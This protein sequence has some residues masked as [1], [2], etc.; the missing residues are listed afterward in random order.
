MIER[1]FRKVAEANKKAREEVEKERLAQLKDEE[2][3]NRIRLLNERI[4]RLDRFP[5]TLAD[6]NI[7]KGKTYEILDSGSSN[8][9]VFIDEPNSHPWI[10]REKEDTESLAKLLEQGCVGFVYYQKRQAWKNV[11][12]SNCTTHYTAYQGF[13]VPIREQRVRT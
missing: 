9:E 4:D 3:T 7:F 5:G 6:Y 12:Y 8:K 13:G 1:I 2:E 11:N 10:G